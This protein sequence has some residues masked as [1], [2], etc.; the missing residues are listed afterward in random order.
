LIFARQSLFTAMRGGLT[1]VFSDKVRRIEDTE[2][3]VKE[4]HAKIGKLAVENDFLSQGLKSY[5]QGIAQQCPER[6]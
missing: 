5:R 3:E 2:A 6:R 1:G 4:L